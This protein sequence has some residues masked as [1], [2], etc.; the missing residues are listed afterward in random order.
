[1]LNLMIEGMRLRDISDLPF[2]LGLSVG[3]LGRRHPQP[4]YERMVNGSA[5]RYRR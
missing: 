1:M 4:W 2:D 3:K 5:H